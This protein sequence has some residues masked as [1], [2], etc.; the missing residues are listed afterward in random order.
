MPLITANEA[1]LIQRNLTKNACDVAKCD[2]GIARVKE[3]ARHD[4]D[5]RALARVLG[6]LRDTAAPM[7]FCDVVGAA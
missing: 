6:E 3:L 1:A 5:L 2:V 7:L 4:P